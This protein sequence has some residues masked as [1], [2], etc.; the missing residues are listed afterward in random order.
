MRQAVAA[1]LL[2]WSGPLSNGK[3]MVYGTQGGHPMSPLIASVSWAGP[4]APH[5]AVDSIPSGCRVGRGLVSSSGRTAD[6]GGAGD[7][8]AR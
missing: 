1:L 4:S 2:G 5:R 8:G 7:E 3:K 6:T